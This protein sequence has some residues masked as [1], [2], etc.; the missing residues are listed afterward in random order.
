MFF[1]LKD[2]ETLDDARVYNYFF[3]FK[4]FFGYRAVFSG[5]KSFFNLGKTTFSVKIQL[6][7]T[8]SDIIVLFRFFLMMFLPY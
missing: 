3:F 1:S 5:Y 7:M 4:F 2:L 8:Q 6:I